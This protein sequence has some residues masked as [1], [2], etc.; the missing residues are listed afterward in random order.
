VELTELLSRVKRALLP[1]AGVRAAL[2]FGSRATGR[3][4]PDSD[5]DIAVLLET[6]PGPDERKGVLWSLL[7]ALGSE[8][9]SD[10]VD[11]VLLNEAPPKLAFEVLKQGRVVFERDPVE[12]HRLRVRTY[13]RHA[14][15][16]PVERFFREVTKRRAQA[17][18]SRG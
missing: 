14:D 5:I 8:L 10:R 4:R 18:V 6:A 9:R 1:M 11:L 17:P 7:T 2:V 15:Y 13:S 3:A 12:L 16:E